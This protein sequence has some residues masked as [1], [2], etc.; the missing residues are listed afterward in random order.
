MKKHV[1]VVVKLNAMLA[2]LV[3]GIAGVAALAWHRLPAEAAEAFLWEAG[4]VAVVVIAAGVLLRLSVREGILRS[5]RAAA[6]VIGRVAEGDLTARVTVQAQGETQ[7]MLNGLQRMTTDL[8]ALVTEVT[9]SAHAVAGRSAQMAQGQRAFAA[10]SDHQASTL[11]ETASAMEELTATVQH[12][13]DNARQASELARTASEVAARGG[14]V[15]GEVVATM[16]GIASSAGRIADISGVIDSI[17]FQTNILAL[18]AAVEAARAGDQGRGFAVVAAEVRTLAQRSAAAAREIKA[19]IGDS[20][21]K[22][23]AGH[24]LVTGAGGT[25]GEI[26]QAVERVSVLVAEIAAASREQSTGIGQVNTAVTE[27]EQG[28]HQN[29]AMVQEAAEATTALAEEA[30]ALLRLV[31]RFRVGPEAAPDLRA[32]SALIPLAA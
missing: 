3:A 14:K 11:E 9:H 23:E 25:M 13:A 1:S 10:R 7:K 28:V 20:V 21:D 15:M 26:V 22:V 19:L 17:A 16:D 27:L 12:N 31:A 6:H 4:L 24:K 30:A 8:A 5:I 32:D 29:A 2:L 18:N